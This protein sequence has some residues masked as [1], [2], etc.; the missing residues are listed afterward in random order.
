MDKRLYQALSRY[1]VLG[2]FNG[3]AKS[4]TSEEREERRAESLAKDGTNPTESVL[5]NDEILEAMLVIGMNIS[6][7]LEIF[8]DVS[9]LSLSIRLTRSE[10]APRRLIF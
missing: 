8:V 2:P 3:W 10:A 4:A 1:E 5:V 7:P 9:A 6:F